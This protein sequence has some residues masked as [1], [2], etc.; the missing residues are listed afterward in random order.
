MKIEKFRAT[1]LASQGFNG[2]GKQVAVDVHCRVRHIPT[3]VSDKI[4]L[5]GP[6][7]VV[8]EYP[9]PS[10]DNPVSGVEMFMSAILSKS[11]LL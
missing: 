8:F 1:I 10:Q 9:D 11:R 3:L 4:R 6:G 2:V 5:S 7:K